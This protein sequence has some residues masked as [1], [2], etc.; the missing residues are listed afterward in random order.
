PV[1]IALDVEAAGTDR[2]QPG[3][4]RI[5]VP[6]RGHISGMHDLREPD[7]RCICAQIELVDERLETAFAP[8]VRVLGARGVKRMRALFVSNG[9]DPVG[10]DVEDLCLRIDESPD[11]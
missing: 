6:I 11:K 5:T 1:I 9:E 4:E 10:R 3:P 7:E 8:S 2:L